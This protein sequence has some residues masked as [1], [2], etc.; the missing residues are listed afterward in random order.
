[1]IIAQ[2]YFNR[3]IYL[4]MFYSGGDASRIY[5]LNWNLGL[6]Y[7]ILFDTGK[8][9]VTHYYAKSVKNNHVLALTYLSFDLNIHSLSA[10]YMRAAIM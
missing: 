6:S 4:K 8:R 10:V 1:M 5:T 9:K 2:T 7:S 3:D